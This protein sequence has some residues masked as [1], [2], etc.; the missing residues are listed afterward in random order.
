MRWGCDLLPWIAAVAMPSCHSCSASLL[1]PCLVR[2]KTSAWSMAC[3]RTRCDS[4]SRLRAR[5]TG[6]TTWR[7]RSIG[8]VG[9]RDLD[10]CRP[11]EQALG[12]AA[13][14]PR[15]GGAEQEVLPPVRQQRQDRADVADEA[16][17]E[18]AIGLVEDE[19]LDRAEIDGAL[20]GVVEQPAGRGD[21]D[22]RA[23]AQRR[24]LAGEAD[25]AEDGGRAGGGPAP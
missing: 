5:S 25:A 21:H 24:H 7:T 10:R 3:V 4:S 8:G 13:D 9:R 22:L 12:Q 23:A 15:E 11:V 19:D 14:L 16:H 18:H 6:W 1:A 17:V 20:A 2:V